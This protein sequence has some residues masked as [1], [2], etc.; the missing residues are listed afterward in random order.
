MERYSDYMYMLK[1]VFSGVHNSSAKVFQIKDLPPFTTTEQKSPSLQIATYLSQLLSDIHQ[2][3]L[4]NCIILP[5]LNSLGHL[6]NSSETDVLEALRELRKHGYDNFV[7][8]LYGHI[9]LWSGKTGVSSSE[10]QNACG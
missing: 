9:T 6:F 3:M 10:T 8:G 7:P 2:T 4:K 5:S 1:S